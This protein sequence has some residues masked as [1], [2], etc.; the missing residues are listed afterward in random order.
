[1]ICFFSTRLFA[2]D[3][4]CDIVECAQEAKAFADE[5]EVTLIKLGPFPPNNDDLPTLDRQQKGKKFKIVILQ[6]DRWTDQQLRQ[7][8][9]ALLIVERL[10]RQPSTKTECILANIDSL[11]VMNWWSFFNS[12]YTGN[13][14]LPS[15]H[16]TKGSYIMLNIRP[17][18]AIRPFQSGEGYSSSYNAT[19]GRT[20]KRKDPLKDRRLRWNLGT[21][22]LY[23]REDAALLGLLAVDWK[24]MD[25]KF[26]AFNIGLARLQF[27][28]FAGDDIK[29]GEVGIGIE[30]Y[31][32]GFNLISAGYQD[33][34]SASKRSGW[35]FQSGILIN[36]GELF[37]ILK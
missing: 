7:F 9:D 4:C 30:T 14:Q 35:Y 21:E 29:G 28:G 25:I 36:I 31:V 23:Q 1:M 2:Q 11:D 19:F 8:R 34:D 10:K 37:Q 20:I 3:K 5:L 18:G 24:I 15:P 16:F 32:L 33:I 12:I 6:Q 13:T 17:F 27:Q 26:D 22:V